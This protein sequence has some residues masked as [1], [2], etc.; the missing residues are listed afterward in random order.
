MEKSETNG[1]PSAL[2]ALPWWASIFIVVVCTLAAFWFLGGQHYFAHQ[3]EIE[4][5]LFAHQD[6][7]QDPGRWLFW[8]FETGTVSGSLALLVSASFVITIKMQK[9]VGKNYQAKIFKPDFKT[10]Q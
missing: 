2:K 1:Q 5:S 3:S 8:L 6:E 4:Y 7:A 9:Y 10:K